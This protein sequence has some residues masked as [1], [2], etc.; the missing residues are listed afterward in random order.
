MTSLTKVHNITALAVA[1]LLL[2]IA[3]ATVG[4]FASPPGGPF[5]AAVAKADDDDDHRGDRRINP[6]AGNGEKAC[7]VAK[8][9]TDGGS[10]TRVI[11]DR[12]D[13]ERYEVTVRTRSYRYEIDLARNFR[14]L[15][16]DRDRI[17]GDN[18]DND[19]DDDNGSDDDD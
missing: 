7:A 14:V 4:A 5:A 9:R 2:A 15:D 6:F 11:E 10:C 16:V 19:D 12:D 3:L 1:A 17:A 13:R 18:H 8:R